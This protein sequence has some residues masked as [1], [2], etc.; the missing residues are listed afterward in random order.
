MDYRVFPC[1]ACREMIDTTMQSCRFCGAAIDPDAAAAA[2][3]L[4]QRVQKACG[5]ASS[6]RI[7]AMAMPV[8]FL[9]SFVPF[10]GGVG[11]AGTFLTLLIVPW[12]V[13]QWHIRFG[14]LE[15]PDPDLPRARRAV[16]DAALVWAAMVIVNALWIL[17]R[18]S[19]VRHAR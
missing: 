17:F 3:T 18:L 7:T 9:L 6:A 13:I 1:P 10:I 5:Q 19:L 16:R 11:A 12:N 2:A 4:Q 14:R 8:F 15:S